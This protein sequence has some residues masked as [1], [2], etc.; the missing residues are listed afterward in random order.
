MAAEDPALPALVGQSAPLLEMLE[1]VSRAAGLDRPVLVVGERGTGKEL[2]AAQLHFLSRRWDGPFVKVNCAALAESL[3]ETELFGHEA[4]AFTGAVR[5]RI[6]RFERAHGGTL[7]LDEIASASPAVQ[8]KILRVVE[9]GELERLGAGATTH[10]DVRVIGATNRDLPDEADEGRFRHDLLD[11]LA[12]EVVSVPPVRARGDDIVLLAEHFARAMA[13]EIGWP[14]FPG[15][16]RAA[17]DA[18]M[19]YEW[20]GNVREIRNVVE[21][22][23]CRWNDAGAPVGE[24]DFDPFASA[25]RPRRADGGGEGPSPGAPSEEPAPPLAPERVLP[26]DLDRTVADFE[27]RLLEDALAT[28]RYSQRAT[29][30]HLR[31]SYHQLRN[32]LRKHGLI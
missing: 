21:R 32:R 18:L 6:G 14:D 2:V 15:F 30:R 22:A 25:Y 3:L 29:S 28:Q 8:E 19:G 16:S 7:F 24:L 9:Y 13:F 31:L 5:R 11:R 20:P 27:K 17:R 26:F 10:V 23:V 1:R 4:G 12:F